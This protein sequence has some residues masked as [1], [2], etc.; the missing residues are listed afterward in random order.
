MVLLV[1]KAQI[2][3]A[4]IE[5]LKVTIN[6]GVNKKIKFIVD[7]EAF[8]RDFGVTIL[9]TEN[10]YK[11]ALNKLNTLMRDNNREELDEVKL[12]KLIE[13]NQR[14]KYTIQAQLTIRANRGYKPKKHRVN[15]DTPLSSEEANY[16]ID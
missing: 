3:Y 8:L 16:L 4:A 13:W 12:K 11:V 10:S 6:Y 15:C 2:S 9:P 5:N 1:L 7:I 14:I